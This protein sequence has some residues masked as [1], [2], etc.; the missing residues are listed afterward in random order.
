MI[1]YSAINFFLFQ[2]TVTS[3]SGLGGVIVHVQSELSG[4]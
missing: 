4:Y 3:E 1:V 2:L